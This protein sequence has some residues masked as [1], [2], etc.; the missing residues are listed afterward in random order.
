MWY[1]KLLPAVCLAVL[2]PGVQ[3]NAQKADVLP[4][5]QPETEG[6]SSAGIDSFLSASGRSVNE[7]HSFMFLR[8]GKVI[9]EGWYKPYGPQLKHSLYSLSKSFTST[10]VGFAVAEKKLT[11]ND[12]VVSFFPGSLP[13]TVSPYFTSL[14]VKDLLTMSVG[15]DPDPTF[16]VASTSTN[17]VK[18]FFTIPIQNKPGTKFLYN[19]LAT[20]MLSAI[21][22]KVTGQ[23]IVD[24]LKPRLFTPLGITGQDW[25]VNTSGINTGGWGLRLK[26]E[27]I[28]KMGQLY[29]QK[30]N[31]KG[32]QLLPAAWVEE[33][34]SFKIDQAPGAPQSK[35]DSSDWMQGYCYQFW[36]CRNNAYRGDG[37]F[38][39]YMIV[40]PEQDAVVAI[41]C[42]T[43]DMQNEINLV[44]QYLLPAMQKG[45][46]PADKASYTHLQQQLSS[47]ALQPLGSNIKP[48]ASVGGKTFQLQANAQHLQSIA[49][50]EEG[51]KYRLALRN[52]TASYTLPFG[53]GEWLQAETAMPGPGLV[54]GAKEDFSLL[55]PYKT[56]GSYAWQDAQTL[57]L[58]LRYIQSPHS[59]I[60]TCH[61]NGPEIVVT[62]ENS[63]EFGSRRTELKGTLVK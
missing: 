37:A 62:E 51:G 36:R 47:L 45:N 22:Q 21:V 55:S 16:A 5:S 4:R 11:V 59:L 28:A 39:Q 17:W 44:W 42:E 13:D 54:A 53:N 30:G 35:K 9:A 3:L 10:A 18:S 34:T 2:L 15:Q 57:K 41:T 49:F 52:D 24:Y 63:F 31:W 6:V 8:H 58:K 23:K 20:Y 7:L 50:V 25:E 26:T 12:K 1:K 38:G 60:I 40:M 33:A 27:D 43:P 48:A 29:L 32:K 61:F 56:A 46:L 14:T 19:T